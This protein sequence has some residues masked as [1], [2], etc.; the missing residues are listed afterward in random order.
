MN[1]LLYF[2]R[3]LHTTAIFT[4][5][6]LKISLGK[7]LPL[8]KNRCSCEKKLQCVWTITTFLQFQLKCVRALH[9][10]FKTDV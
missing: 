6:F 9:K 8:Y 3:P 2:L 4:K 10:V 1:R 5:I 7:S